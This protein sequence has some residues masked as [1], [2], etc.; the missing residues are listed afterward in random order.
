LADYFLRTD[1]PIS[2]LDQTATHE[3]SR[4]DS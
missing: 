4:T 2:L 1:S 3:A